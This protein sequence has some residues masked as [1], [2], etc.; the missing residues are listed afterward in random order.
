[1]GTTVCMFLNMF[2]LRKSD[3]T[4]VSFW[5]GREI[6]LPWV[7][8]LLSTPHWPHWT[9]IAASLALERG[10]QRC[11]FRFQWLPSNTKL[12]LSGFLSSAP[13]GP[14]YQEDCQGKSGAGCLLPAGFLSLLCQLCCCELAHPQFPP[15]PSLWS[16]HFLFALCLLCSFETFHY[17]L[18]RILFFLFI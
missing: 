3:S 7:A 10:S 5:K 11:I 4:V 15:H 1:M 16:H 8:L 12:G 13:T 17:H 9:Q 6:D 2:H 14:D 18:H